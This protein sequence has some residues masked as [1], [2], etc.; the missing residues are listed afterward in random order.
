MKTVFCSFELGHYTCFRSGLLF[1]ISP[2]PLEMSLNFV[3]LVQNKHAQL[4][5]VIVS[6]LSTR[7]SVCKIPE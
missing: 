5:A 7:L 2:S 4:R 3:I 1:A 6:F